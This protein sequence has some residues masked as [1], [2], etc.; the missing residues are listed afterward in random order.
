MG[1]L[2]ATGPARHGRRRAPKP[3]SRPVLASPLVER[4]RP[5]SIGD[6][7]DKETKREILIL[8]IGTILFEAPF[9]ALAALTVLSH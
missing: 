7:M 1:L 8:T 3:N 2:T 5:L 9:V 6:A 4:S